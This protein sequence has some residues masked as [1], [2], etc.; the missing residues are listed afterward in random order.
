M[1]ES[2][3]VRTIVVAA[4]ANLGIAVAKAIGGVV[5]GSSAML[6]EAAHSVADTTTEVLLLI[7]VQRGKKPADARHPL[8]HGRSAFVWALI[9]AG[10]TFVAGGGFAITQGIHTLSHGEPDG[11]IWPSLIVLAIAFVLESISLRQ[12]LKQAS[13][14]ASVYR[15]GLRRY[16]RRTSNTAV[17]AIVLEDLAALAGLILAALGLVLSKLTGSPVWDGLASMAIGA[18]LIFVAISLIRS[19]A[20]LL[21]GVAVPER[22]ERELQKE[23]SA[24]PGVHQVTELYTSVIGMSEVLVAARAVFVSDGDIVAAANVAERRLMARY[25]VIRFVFLTPTKVDE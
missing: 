20:S 24:V 15:A 14:E 3:S 7:A 1:A 19:N 18:M 9:A 16:L 5:S 25:P 21:I 2:E 10:F 4:V 13:A 11:N 23:L 12:G 22:L 8:G 6:S 17:K